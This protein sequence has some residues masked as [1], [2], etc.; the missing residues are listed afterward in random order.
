MSDDNFEL[1]PPTSLRGN[2]PPNSNPNAGRPATG[3]LAWMARNSVAANL[4]MGALIFG[5]LIFALFGMIKQEVFPEFQLDVISISV[6]YPGA[7]PEEVEKGITKAIE[8]NVRGVD[9]VKTVSSTSAANRSD[10]IPTD[11]ACAL[12][13]RNITVSRGP[14]PDRDCLDRIALAPLAH[15]RRRLL[16]L[17]IGAV[18][19]DRGVPDECALRIEGDHLAA[20]AKTGID[21]EHPARAKGGGEQQLAEVVGEDRDRLLIGAFL[22][23]AARLVLEHV[24]IGV[25]FIYQ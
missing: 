25:G 5:G 19:E 2:E 24:E 16:A 8:E 14:V 9:G 1:P 17:T 18:G 10:V 13:R 20:G 12:T 4:L 6:P 7:S 11:A 22:Q 15:R 3:P 21:R 23:P